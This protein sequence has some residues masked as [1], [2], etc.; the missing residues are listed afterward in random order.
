MPAPSPSSETL[1]RRLMRHAETAVLTTVGGPAA[2]AGDG[3]PYGALVLVATGADGAPLLL[4]SDLAEHC[5]HL[6]VDGRAALVFDGT[7]DHADPLTGPRATVLGEL[8]HSDDPA[9]S[10]RFLRRHPSAEVYADFTDFNF[11]RMTITQAH[12]VAGFGRIEWLSA[13]SLVAP[14]CAALAADE[15][16]VIAHMNSDHADAIAV[17]A[18]AD[19]AAGWRMVGCDAEGCDLRAGARLKRID[20]PAPVSDLE[21][22]RATLIALA[23]DGRAAPSQINE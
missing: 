5:H 20:F 21:D 1:V 18:G 14:A 11:Y 23:R 22:L 4:L 9:L 12:L 15:A 16:G 8:T 3:W 7:R 2:R 19:L 17:Y 13:E 6:A 10:Q